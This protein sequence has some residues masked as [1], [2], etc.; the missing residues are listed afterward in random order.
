MNEVQNPF[1]GMVLAQQNHQ[2]NAVIES[3]TARAVAEVQASMIIA[4]RFPRNPIQATDNIINACT[5]QMLAE[6]AMYSFSRGGTDITGP[7]V[8]LAEMMAQNWGNISYGIRELSQA[9]G[10]S[11]VEAFAHDLETN[12]KQVKVF[13]VPHIRYS[14]AKGNTKLS[15]PRD[16][17]ELTANNGARRLRACILGI[18]PG[19]LVET[20]VKQCELTLR[21]KA[22]VTPERIQSLLEKF[23]EYHV[24]KEMIEKRIQRRIE[25]LTPALL[26]QL[27][28]IF[29]SLKDGMSTAKDWFQ[30]EP[31]AT[32]KL[33]E[34]TKELSDQYQESKPVPVSASKE[35]KL[36]MAMKDHN[37]DVFKSAKKETGLQPDTIENCTAIMDAISRINEINKE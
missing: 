24:T 16:I 25:A 30:V 26:V 36:L 19:D 29:N 10:E 9:N 34:L 5:R 4:K 17:Y 18:L 35:Y 23:A 6:T 2:N 15:D 27:G 12:T 37:H 3:E 32:G 33:A 11:T 22:D 8:R 1:N 7:S 20:A 14:K 28:K 13:Q 31:E 21:T